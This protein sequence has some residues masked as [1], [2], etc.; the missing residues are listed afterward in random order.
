MNEIVYDYSWIG[1]KHPRTLTDD[2]FEHFVLHGG[3][4]KGLTMSQMVKYLAE[5]I[6]DLEP[7]SLKKLKTDVAEN[8][9]SINNNVSSINTITTDISNMKA[10]IGPAQSKQVSEG[11]FNTFK[12][13]GLF[14]SNAPISSVTWKNSRDTSWNNGLISGNTTKINTNT[15]NINTNADAISDIESDIEDIE[16]DV[17]TNKGNITT[18]SGNITTNTNSISTN[19][20]NITTNTNSISTNTGNITTNTNSISTNTGNI[21]TNTNSISTNSG[22]I[23]TN[24]NGISTNKTNIKTNKDNISTNTSNIS[25]INT[26]VGADEADLPSDTDFTTFESDG[27]YSADV[28]IGGVA[29]QNTK[30]IKTN[31]TNI[32]TNTTNISN[33]D[34]AQIAT[35][36]TDIATINTRTGPNQ[37]ASISGTNYT[38]FRT[39]GLYS[40]NATMGGVLWKNTKN[41]ETNKDNISTNSTSITTNSGSITTNT[42]NITTN[43]N[44]ISTN[45]TN[46]KTNKD[47]I[48]TNTGNITTNSG[49]ITTNTGNITTNADA[50]SDAESDIDDLEDLVGPLQ[51]AKPSSSDMI[52]FQKK[53][54]DGSG[55]FKTG[56]TVGG[57]T[58]QN[59]INTS[60]LETRVGPDQ[61]ETPSYTNYH[62]FRGN[63]LYSSN[64]TLGGV[65]WQNT[66]EI[67]TLANSVTSSQTK[68]GKLESLVGSAQASLPSETH[69]NTF[70]SNGLYVKNQTTIGG[71]A[72]QNAKNISTN[73]TN[74]TANTS[75]IS[76]NTTNI[77]TNTT[78][79]GNLE[80]P[81]N[82]YNW[83]GKTSIARSQAS[84]WVKN[85]NNWMPVKTITWTIP[86]KYKLV[87]NI[88]YQLFN[89]KANNQ[90]IKIS[91]NTKDSNTNTGSMSWIVKSTTTNRPLDKFGGNRQ[92]GNHSFDIGDTH[93]PYVDDFT[94]NPT[95][96]TEVVYDQILFSHFLNSIWFRTDVEVNFV[97]VFS[98]LERTCTNVTF[99]IAVFKSIM[100]DNGSSVMNLLINECI[101]PDSLIINQKTVT[102]SSLVKADRDVVVPTA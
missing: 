38:N 73:S 72:Y 51:A 64:A 53:T 80:N 42:G 63:G 69:F 7:P 46:I 60:G 25:K 31:K 81:I 29:Y 5:T 9:I 4:S 34:T 36:K 23:T 99:S 3:F 79:I 44:G 100:T 43:T 101:T 13:N 61:A 22:N 90:R 2:E 98:N 89:N 27:E 76:T 26:R 41:I 21:T 49:N 82:V 94:N 74:I 62:N 1:K 8:T 88:K 87:S 54:G 91:I 32:S 66:K 92:F 20:G 96:V 86:T 14:S 6:D 40:S 45:K 65:N 56:V 19:T 71:V 102:S 93:L 10:Y 95:S 37:A 83:L 50:I 30:N 52:K 48:S 85:L 39:N 17:S 15:E 67:S 24:T 58:W 12:N 28:T 84:T 57:V 33:I 68:I 75:N 35:N 16:S 18:N 70:K 97:T 47:N 78:K 55:L 59:A 77:S 11:N